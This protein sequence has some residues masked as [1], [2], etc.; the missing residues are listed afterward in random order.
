[1]I[2]N[3]GIQHSTLAYFH[4]G[5]GDCGAV[6]HR[7]LGVRLPERDFEK[8]QPDAVDSH[9]EPPPLILVGLNER[10]HD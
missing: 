6:T 7:G 5:W 4:A 9:D 3:M 8:G 2:Y 10:V 1:M